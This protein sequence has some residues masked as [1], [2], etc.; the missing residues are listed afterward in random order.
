MIIL[1]K[2]EKNT[3][4]SEIHSLKIES[5][6]IDQ[7]SR[8]SSKVGGPLGWSAPE[9]FRQEAIPPHYDIIISYGLATSLLALIIIQHS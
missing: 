9:F 4:L 2:S 6:N 1:I 7:W 5:I 3:Y 8:N